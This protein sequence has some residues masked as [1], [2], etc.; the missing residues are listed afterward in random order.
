MRLPCVRFSVRQLM[1][2][3]VLLAVT[4][5]TYQKWRRSLS[6]ALD[7]TSGRYILLI[8]T[9]QGSSADYDAKRLAAELRY[10]HA[11]PAYIFATKD[12]NCGKQRSER[13]DTSVCV[14]IG[15]TESLKAAQAAV[16]RLASKAITSI[17]GPLR[18]MFA[19][20][21]YL[22]PPNSSSEAVRH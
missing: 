13:A 3:V 18:P 7:R 17:A 21:P 1:T 11:L 4:F 15:H 22:P 2:L 9:F 8:K 16:K 20:N 19:R 6:P 5:F 10:N 12:R 14:F